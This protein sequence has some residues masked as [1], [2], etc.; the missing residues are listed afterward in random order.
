MDDKVVSFRQPPSV[1][2]INEKNE[3]KFESNVI[4]AVKAGIEDGMSQAQMAGVLM[5]IIQDVL[6]FTIGVFDG[7]EP[8]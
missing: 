4:E 3:G 2:D 1:R 6:P 7:D 8:A 5:F